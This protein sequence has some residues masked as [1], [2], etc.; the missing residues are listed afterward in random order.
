MLIR[1]A[2]FVSMPAV[3]ER[4]D[5]LKKNTL[6]GHPFVNPT[7][8]FWSTFRK[9]VTVHMVTDVEIYELGKISD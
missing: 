8:V 6:P 4:V 3:L 5:V 7:E 2:P 9:C 1:T